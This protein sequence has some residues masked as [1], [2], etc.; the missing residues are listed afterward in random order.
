MQLQ[1]PA[2]VLSSDSRVLNL[3]NEFM[4]EHQVEGEVSPD[5]D[6]LV[7]RFQWEL[8]VWCIRVPASSLWNDGLY[9]AVAE[10]LDL[11]KRVIR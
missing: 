7:F 2:R 4:T 10:S 11:A 8:H 9:R 5:G 3:V 1:D 6:D